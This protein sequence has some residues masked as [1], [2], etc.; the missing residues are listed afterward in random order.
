MILY[1]HS[2]VDRLVAVLYNPEKIEAKK[3]LKPLIR[4]LKQHKVR[5]LTKLDRHIL[6][7]ADFAIV[8]GG[9]TVL[10]CVLQER[11]D[12]WEFPFWV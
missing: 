6:P 10:F 1:N 8:L 9:G 11:W 4:W 7:G 12:L 5:V 2:T 3:A